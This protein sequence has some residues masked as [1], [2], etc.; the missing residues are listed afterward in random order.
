MRLSV[1]TVAF[2]KIGGVGLGGLIVKCEVVV[3]SPVVI[4]GDG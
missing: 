4:T 1:G 3:A 2:V